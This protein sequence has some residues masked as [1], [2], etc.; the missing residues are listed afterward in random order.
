VSNLELSNQ[1]GRIFQSWSPLAGARS[2]PTKR[3]IVAAVL[4]HI[5]IIVWT[6]YDWRF[7]VTPQPDAIPVT[8]VMVPPPPPPAPPLPATPP[9]PPPEF[10]KRES[11]P[12]EKTTALPPAEAPAPAPEAPA[13]PEGPPLPPEK[14]AE[15]ETAPPVDGGQAPPAKP[16]T[17]APPRKEAAIPRAP[18]QAT[19]SPDRAL[20][21]KEETGDPYLNRLYELIEQH[22]APT[23]PIGA[24][25]L[26]LEGTSVYRVVV[27]RT[28]KVTFITLLQTS[29]AL[30]LDEEARRMITAMIPFPPLP[31]DYP[32]RVGI[33]V[34]IHLYPR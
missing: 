25:G 18:K 20:G 22:R 27:E 2:R 11:G 34:T 33:T 10:A 29:G 15:E 8:L 6:S 19:R 3:A 32:D 5:L 9:P 13:Q 26:H 4:L 24:M 28:G 12:E 21:E 30:L 16:A 1:A 17:P 14:P 23:T 31:A 7:A